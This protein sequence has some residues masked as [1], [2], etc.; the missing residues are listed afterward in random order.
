M[1]KNSNLISKL[2]KNSIDE[3]KKDG[4]ISGGMIP[5]IDA[6]LECIRSGVGTAHIIDGKIPHSLLLEIFTDEGIGSIIQWNL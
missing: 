4:T 3:L 6:C 2:D 5:K 1:D